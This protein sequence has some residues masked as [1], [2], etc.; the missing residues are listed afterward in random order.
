MN[1]CFLD[2]SKVCLSSCNLY[3]C[4]IFWSG[5][6]LRMVIQGHRD[7][8]LT[9][10]CLWSLC[11]LPM[12]PTSQDSNVQN[13]DSILT[14]WF[15]ILFC[16]KTTVY[17]FSQRTMSCQGKGGKQ[18]FEIAC[19]SRGFHVFYELWKPKLGQ[20]LHGRQG[21]GNLHNPFAIFLR[22]KIPGKLTDFDAVRD[23]L[24]K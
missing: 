15:R 14:I 17:L 12:L 21:I 3:S 6:S 4:F 22:T 9:V 13:I 10:L 16:K 1:L 19:A 24:K 18:Q 7:S 8:F 5:L 2:I 20:M 11:N 23:N